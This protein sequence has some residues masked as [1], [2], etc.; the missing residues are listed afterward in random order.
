MP[1][2]SLNLLFSIDNITKSLTYNDVVKNLKTCR[3]DYRL[4][5]S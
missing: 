1:K 5:R 4:L 2:E 3:K